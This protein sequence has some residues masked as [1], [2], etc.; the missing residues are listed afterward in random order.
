MTRLL[1]RDGYV[2][3]MDPDIGVLERGS[4]LVEDGRISAVRSDL[5]HIDAEVIDAH[6]AVIM[7]GF[8]DTRATPGRSRSCR[9]VWTGRCGTTSSGSA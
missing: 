2:L 8:I 1:I 3:S 6:G 9:S 5:E 4:V 7:P